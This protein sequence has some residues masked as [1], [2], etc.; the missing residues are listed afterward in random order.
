MDIAILFLLLGEAVE[1]FMPLA[2]K[3]LRQKSE[4]RNPKSEKMLELKKLN[5]EQERI[6]QELKKSLFC[7][8]KGTIHIVDPRVK[9][10]DDGKQQ[11]KKPAL[12]F[13]VTGSGKTE[14]YIKLAQEV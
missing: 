12:I 6:F 11:V 1:L 4:I 2:I 13:G 14:I 10:E 5:N 3:N 7:S 9:L 8:V